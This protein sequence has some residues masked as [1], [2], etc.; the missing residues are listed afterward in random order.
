MPHQQSRRV[1][2]LAGAAL[3]AALS[4]AAPAPAAH[5][6]IVGVTK[7]ADTNDG[8]CDADCS[9]R[10]AVIA[11]NATPG[12]AV[13]NLP[14]GVYTLTL[15]G[16]DD[17][18]ALGDLDIADDVAI[19]GAAASTTV[20]D[21][22]AHDRVFEILGGRAT[23]IGVTVRNGDLAIGGGGGGISNR[24]G[25]SL[26]LVNSVVSGNS[27]TF[28]GGIR[29]SGALA[30]TSSV[31]SGNSTTQTGGGIANVGGTLAITDSTIVGNDTAGLGGGI[32]NTGVAA[33]RNSA[34]ISNTAS[35]ADTGGGGGLFNFGVS[36]VNNVVLT[37]ANSTISGNSAAF[38]GGGLY[39]IL[40]V[41]LLSSTTI[42]NN[43][44]D[45]DANGTGDG[46]GI[47]RIPDNGQVF[48]KQTL[49]AGN[50]DSGG[51]APDCAT[52]KGFQQSQLSS[53]GYN[54]V[55]DTA[56]CDIGGATSGDITG[57]DPKVGGLRNNGGPT[58][59]HALLAGSP[60]LDAGNPAGCADSQGR[61]LASDQRGFPRS[62]GGACDIGAYELAAGAAPGAPPTIAKRFFPAA[63]QLGDRA[64]L[65]FT[66]TNSL[67]GPIDGVAF[68]DAMP[69]A[70]RIASG[71]Q[72]STCGGTINANP[73]E[74]TISLTD[75]TLASGA[76]CRIV[77]PVTSAVVGS[78]ANVAGPISAAQ[79]GTGATSNVA[80]LVVTKPPRIYIPIVWR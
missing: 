69:P 63:I 36:T 59:T 33:I 68:A 74:S 45:R 6:T 23:L 44:A 35:G 58:P 55:Q 57:Q 62:Q 49:L 39:N 24:A 40:G 56:G 76:A 3:I 78:H 16:A 14:A 4:L 80:T 5:A 27:A 42:V 12:P 10:E 28:G 61:P 11:A 50:V 17:T 1:Y 37:V 67:T 72:F 2:L 43:R 41:T 71:P 64:T 53:Q 46:G 48:L 66:I 70:I 52:H 13:I 34:I 19:V 20:V 26:T 15:G 21:G 47:M 73:G 65:D 77:V 18:A 54:L 30:V 75:G 51:Q 7:T 79:T 32:Y 60:A 8:V 29:S 9:L 22:A 38:D 25:A 31:I